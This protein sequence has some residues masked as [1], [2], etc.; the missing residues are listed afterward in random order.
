MTPLRSVK[1]VMRSQYLLANNDTA[2]T[3]TVK[4]K[5]CGEIRNSIGI[6]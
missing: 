3:I 6:T 5:H 2:E 1:K 4:F